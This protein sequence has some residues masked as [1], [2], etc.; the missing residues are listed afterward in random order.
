[1]LPRICL[2]LTAEAVAEA[3]LS[4]QSK[5]IAGDAANVEG[6][7]GTLTFAAQQ[8]ARFD[9]LAK[10]GAGTIESS[11]QAQSNL[12]ER[13]EALERDIAT[14]AAARGQVDVLQS[15][16]EQAKGNVAQAQAALRQAE[17]NLS[18]T[19]IYAPSA[20]TVASRF[21]QV[22]NLVQPGQTLFSAVPD[23]T[24]VKAQFQ[25]DPAGENAGWPASH[26]HGRCLPES[27]AAWAHRQLPA[28]YGF[29]FRSAA[30]GERDRQ[31]RNDRAACSG[32]DPSR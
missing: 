32:E 25:G 13:Q 16:I 12:T 18:Y 31:L 20:G 23:E 19:K 7:R 27:H 10:T 29:E 14:L 9:S 17:L 21:V 2:V 28:R 15:Q 30:A 11:Q 24:Y 22:G 8:L 1:M 6:D 26:H 5:V 4:E 3:Q